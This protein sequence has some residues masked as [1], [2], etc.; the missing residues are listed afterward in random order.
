MS[1]IATPPTAD[2]AAPFLGLSRRVGRRLRLGRWLRA[3][4]ATAAPWHVLLLALLALGW[5]S[6][7]SARA[8]VGLP[9]PLAA[10]A[11]VALWL[12]ACGLWACL[13]TPG[14]AA[15]L[16]L[17][18]EAAGHHE[19]FLSALSLAAD[20]RRGPGGDL[21]L[22]RAHAALARAVEEMPA[23][24][25][26]RPTVRCAAWPLALLAASLLGLPSSASAAGLAERGPDATQVS[27]SIDRE[28]HALDHLH[29][30]MTPEEKEKLADLRKRLRK[31][32]AA[33][34]HPAK[35]PTARQV[36]EELERRARE[37]EK[38]ARLLGADGETVSSALLAELERHADTAS[39]A[40]ALRAAKLD[41]AAKEAGNL[42]RRL[43][44]RDLSLEAR[45]RIQE[46]FRAGLAKATPQDRRT[47]LGGALKAAAAHLAQKE[48][49][50]AAEEMERLAR[51][52]ER[53]ARR[54]RSMQALQR[55]ARNLRASGQEALGRTAGPLTRL[56]RLA[57]G[58]AR[59]VGTRGAPVRLGA[60]PG[61]AP[62]NGPSPGA[63]PPA[64]RRG[65]TP[66]VPG[67]EP[68]KAGDAPPA[69]VC[70]ICGRPLAGKGPAPVPGAPP[71]PGTTP[72]TPGAPPGGT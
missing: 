22:D 15:R 55:L 37:A 32:A 43:R 26:L 70:P 25:P 46:A 19:M 60:M 66:P 35:D 65:A 1:A 17:F 21:H 7:T 9:L 24:L 33:L 53:M 23:A 3:L 16:A 38:L 59:A 36:L 13:T 69:G 12:L 52:Y 10:L 14:P 40:G 5:A 61:P 2:A 51:R 4:R 54:Q 57:P 47:L 39:L 27:A 34:A 49:R 31:S 41:R 29:E 58:P 64:G 45:Q 28:A 71:V 30:G 6:G 11:A 68:A 67:T 63:A 44:A 48:P 56:A 72:P 50:P 42:G 62:R 18:D 20:P 8:L